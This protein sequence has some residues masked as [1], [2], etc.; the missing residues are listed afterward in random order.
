MATPMTSGQFRQIVEPIINKEFDG[1]YK[2]R[3]DEWKGVFNDVTPIQRAY[4][5]EPVMFG[6]GGAPEKPEGSPLQYATAGINYQAR[7]FFKVYGLA[8]A[9]SKEL[10][11]DGDHINIGK[12]YG[13]FLAQSI[14]DTIET[15][16]ANNLNRA[17]NSSYVGGDGVALASA[18]HPL[19]NGGTYSN[20][21]TAAAMSQTSVEQA[22]IN[23]RNAVN[24]TGLKITL[25][26]ELIVAAPSNM[27]QGQVILK[28]ILRTGTANNDAN[29]LN[30]MMGGE[31]HIISRLTSPTAWFVK[32]D[33][34]KGLQIMF[35]RKVDK[36]ME[37]DFDTD[38]ARYKATVRFQSGWTDPRGTWCNAGL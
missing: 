5:E 1:I 2:L 34:P 27:I 7:Y 6:F 19:A 20:L 26:P 15:L 31:P 38:T 30:G 12:I 9:L 14:S 18:S 35:R 24:D 33:A 36:G 32:T 25:K 10:E 4:H 13:Q 29:I 23:I 22:V 3:A 8:F 17:F 21:L 11:E 28:S 37:G 16:P